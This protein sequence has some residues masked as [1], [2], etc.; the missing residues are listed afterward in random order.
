MK[1]VLG[2][3][4][5]VVAS[6]LFL[7]WGAPSAH[8]SGTASNITG[9]YYTGDKH[10]SNT[11]ATQGG[12][13]GNWSVTY[14]STNG[15]SSTN[16]TYEGAAYVVSSQYVDGAWTQNTG[17]AQ[18]IT[19]PGAVTTSGT[20]PNT[21][22]DDLPGNGDTGANAGYYLY[23][24][25]FTISG[26]GSGTVSNNVAISLTISADDSYYVFV[27]PSGNGTAIPSGGTSSASVSGTSAWNNT[28]SITLANYTSSTQGITNNASFVIGTNYLVVGVINSNSINGTS[29]TNTNV[30]PSGLL[31]Y[32]VGS[33]A[34]INGKPIPEMDTWVPVA[35]AAAMAGVVLWR[36]RQPDLVPIR[37]A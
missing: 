31:V 14:A 33:V 11:L 22:G 27:N 35:L 3:L 17:S 34:L 32:Q 12:T 15:G 7:G 37:A 4:A 1:R 26:T 8:A 23:T 29:S 6:E 18:W 13:D 9:L 24:L 25:A 16:S 5:L 28:T 36:R 19:A 20:N 10:D 21:G 30:N 2:L